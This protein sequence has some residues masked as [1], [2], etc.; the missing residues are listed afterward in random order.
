MF[1]MSSFYRVAIVTFVN[2]FFWNLICNDIHVWNIGVLR[3]YENWSLSLNLIFFKFHLKQ[4]VC[5]ISVAILCIVISASIHQMKAPLLKWHGFYSMYPLPKITPC[6]YWPLQAAV[7]P[8]PNEKSTSYL[9]SQKSDFTFWYFFF[10]LPA[11]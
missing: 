3:L 4:N 11:N 1:V 9:G 5:M 10:F 6:R 8:P 2:I 7:E